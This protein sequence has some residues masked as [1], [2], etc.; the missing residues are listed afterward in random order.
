MRVAL[1]VEYCGTAFR[2]WQSQPGGE[3]VQDVLEKALASICGQPVSVICAGRTDAGVHGTNQVVHFDAPVERPVTAWVRGVN[4]HLPESVAVR[5]AQPVS[6]EFHARFSA[7]GRRY[8]YLLL[9]R[10]QRPGL[11][12]G[13]LGWFHLP[14][15]LAAMQDAAGR[16]LGE[17]DFSA[18]RA[19]GCQAKTPV[20]TMWRADVRQFG[21]LF[22]FDFEA[23]AFLHHM[24]RNLVGSLVYVGKANQSPAW[25][26]TLLQARDRTQSAPTF[27]PDGL[28]FRGPIY[29]PHWDLPDPDDDFLDGVFK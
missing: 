3:T 19:A 27:S 1:G 26:D 5:W 20:K 29:E 4:A 11:W 9:N 25:I 13:R 28:Y 23:S 21:N 2:G 22:V 18:F 16:L 8:R 17:H 14:L 15:D 7:R 6:D 24:V 10:P 12:Q